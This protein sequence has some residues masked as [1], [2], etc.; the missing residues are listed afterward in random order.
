MSGLLGQFPLE[1]GLSGGRGCAHKARSAPSW[2][3]PGPIGQ[4][5]PSSVV[6]VLRVEAGLA[7]WF[8]HS[9]RREKEAA[10]ETVLLEWDSED[11]TSPYSRPVD[12]TSAS[13]SWDV[14]T[15][16]GCWLALDRRGHWCPE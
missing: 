3:L 6:L 9:Q 7:P 12:P 1:A 8:F 14:R 16:V 10:K 11:D 4:A 15:A 2:P 13:R 5:Q